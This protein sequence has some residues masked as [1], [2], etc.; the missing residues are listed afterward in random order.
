MNYLLNRP[1]KYIHAIYATNEAL[2]W[3]VDKL[4]TSI[5]FPSS[6]TFIDKSKLLLDLGLSDDRFLDL[7]ILV[8]SF[9]SRTL[10]VINTVPPEHFI[11]SAADI[12]KT[13]QSGLGAVDFFTSREP[14]RMTHYR[15]DFIRARTAVRHG[16]VLT[17][18]GN[19]VPL[20]LAISSHIQAADVP[21]DIDTIFSQRLPQ[22]LYYY[23]CK[24]MISPLV[25]GW[26]T[27]GNVAEHAPLSDS[28]NY[29]GFVKTKITESETSQR[30]LCLAILLDTLNARWRENRI[31]RFLSIT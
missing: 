21:Y 18:E 12:I 20:P 15:E 10:P 25:V 1:N 2:L 19:V 6:F 23:I 22:D 14:A 16:F 3:P 17:T 7:G 30:V 27:T 8:G 24:G 11:K 31:V 13:H 28:G 9:L 29:Q 4:I 5:D 26:L